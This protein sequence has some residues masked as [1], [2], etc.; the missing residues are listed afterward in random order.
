MKRA[1]SDDSLRCSFCQKSQDV[2]GK[3]IFLPV[4]LS[5]RL[6]LRRVYRR[7]QFDP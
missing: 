2:V 3:L 7:L 6:H 5:S 4:R 1:G